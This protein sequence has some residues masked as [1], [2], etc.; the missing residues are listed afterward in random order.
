[1]YR[2]RFL[3]L[4]READAAFDKIGAANWE[5]PS[6]DRWRESIEHKGLSDV[7]ALPLAING[8]ARPDPLD[9]LSTGAAP[10][11]ADCEGSVET[12]PNGLSG[13]G[14]VGR[15][16]RDGSTPAAFAGL[17]RALRIV[18]MAKNGRAVLRQACR[19]RTSRD[20]TPIRQRLVAHQHPRP[21]VENASAA[22]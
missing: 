11:G 4:H 8:S 13:G 19:L 17:L 10:Q 2:V 6:P 14:G 9:A 15:R 12:C 5:M 16:W 7:V 21:R 1:M 20:A 18:K 22:R 3:A